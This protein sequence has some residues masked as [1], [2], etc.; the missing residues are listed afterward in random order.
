M[1]KL[2]LFALTLFSASSIA[3]SQDQSKP[4]HL[5][6]LSGQSNMAGLKPEVGFLPE[7][8]KLLPDA[9]IVHM[10]VAKGGQPIRLWVKE[11]NDIAGKNEIKVKSEKTPYYDQIL[12]QFK[13]L[14]EKHPKGFSSISFSWM[15]GERDAKEMLSA[16]YEESLKTLISNLRRDLEAPE[17]NVVIGRLSDFGDGRNPEWEKVREILVKVASDDPHG[18]WVDTDDLNNKVKNEKPVNDLHYTKEGYELFGQRLAQQ[19]VKL[20]KGE[21]PSETGK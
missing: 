14:K 9:E 2:F 3:F 10:K 8:K 17:M 18:A 15:Q 7:L 20:L 13:A 16:A 4:V 6:I 1:N 19:S 21:K 12:E 5:F 11:W